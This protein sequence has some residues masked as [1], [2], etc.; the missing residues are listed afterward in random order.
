MQVNFHGC[1]LSVLKVLPLLKAFIGKTFELHR[2][3]AKT[4][5]LFSR[6]ASVAYGTIISHLKLRKL[7]KLN[8][9]R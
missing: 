5:K 2:K 9:L 3:S 4:T 7:P 6:V 8:H 1:A